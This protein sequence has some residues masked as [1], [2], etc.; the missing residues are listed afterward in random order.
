MV[1]IIKRGGYIRSRVKGFIISSYGGEGYALRRCS[2]F[3]RF[4]L[5]LKL[6]CVVELGIPALGEQVDTDCIAGLD[7]LQSFKA[8]RIIGCR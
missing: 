6:F 4:R 8:D 1:N 7:P 3:I 2:E 5:V